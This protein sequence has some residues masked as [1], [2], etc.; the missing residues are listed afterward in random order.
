MLA[1]ELAY[2]RILDDHMQCLGFSE[3]P[4]EMCPGA[5]DLMQAVHRHQHA[6]QE[7]GRGRLRSKAHIGV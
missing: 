4:S 5:S 2:W 1:K 7:P 6:P 3:H